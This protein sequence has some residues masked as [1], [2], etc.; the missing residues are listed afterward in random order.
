V[1]QPFTLIVLGGDAPPISNP[2]CQ[3]ETIEIPMLPGGQY[4]LVWNYVNTGPGTGP[5]AVRLTFSLAA[6]G[7]PALGKE[8]LVALAFAIAAVGVLTLRC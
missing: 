8:A 5:P 3:H 6:T 2:V 7:V 4:T 1:S